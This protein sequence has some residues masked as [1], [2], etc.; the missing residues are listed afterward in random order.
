MIFIQRLHAYDQQ[1]CQCN[2][3]VIGI[4]DVNTSPICCLS[5]CAW[6]IFNPK[7]YT[8]HSQNNIKSLIPGCI[9]PRWDYVWSAVRMF[10]RNHLNCSKSN[11]YWCL[12]LIFFGD[13]SL[14]CGA[15]GTLCFGLWLILPMGFKSQGRSIII[16]TLLLLAQNDPQSQFCIPRTGPGPIFVP[17]YGEATTIVTTQCH[18]WMAGRFEPRTLQPKAWRSTN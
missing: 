14:F 13:R 9:E 2:P 10:H 17:W 5:V 11:V 16:C 18:I 15:T 7:Q 3:P 12:F 8:A 1:K 6:Q 4:V